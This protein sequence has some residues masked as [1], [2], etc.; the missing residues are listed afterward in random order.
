MQ[1]RNKTKSRWTLRVWSHLDSTTKV[2]NIDKPL[3][4][5]CMYIGYTLHSHPL[6]KSE[7]KMFDF[8]KILL[9][10]ID[11]YSFQIKLE[12][13][14]LPE[15]LFQNSSRRQ[16]L[17]ACWGG[18]AG[19]GGTMLCQDWLLTRT[20]EDWTEPWWNIHVCFALGQNV[21][22]S[23]R[24]VWSTRAEWVWDDLHR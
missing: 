1:D 23:S 11:W 19:G 8:Q 14:G 3:E 5:S 12:R 4:T 2:W 9:G 6:P 24:L 20:R 10:R 7:F 22:R 16:V 17:L 21:G 18:L 15:L 13:L